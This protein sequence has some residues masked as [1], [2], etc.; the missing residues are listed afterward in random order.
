MLA[1]FLHQGK[2]A[3][4]FFCVNHPFQAIWSR[5]N[6]FFNFFKVVQ[7]HLKREKTK[8]NHFFHLPPDTRMKIF[9]RIRIRKKMR[10]RNPGK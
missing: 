6:F 2:K 1:S 7:N 10:I 3:T 4:Y 9:T 8:K 5:K